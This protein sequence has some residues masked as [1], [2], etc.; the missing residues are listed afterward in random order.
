[1]AGV[2]SPIVVEIVEVVGAY[3]YTWIDPLLELLTINPVTA[4]VVE[5]PTSFAEAPTPELPTVV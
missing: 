3:P 4:T 5:V 2:I 1:M